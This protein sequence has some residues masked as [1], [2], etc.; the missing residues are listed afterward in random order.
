MMFQPMKAITCAGYN[1]NL[2]DMRTSEENGCLSPG[3]D[4]ISF[5]GRNAAF[6]VIVCMLSL[7]SVAVTAEDSL[8]KNTKL[9]P[10]MVRLELTPAKPLIGDT[11]TLEIRVVAEKGVELL[12]PA[13]GE[14]LDRF[15]I[16]DYVPRERIDDD[17]RTI[18][19]QRY[20]LQPPIS[21]KQSI[22]PILIE[23][24]DRRPGRRPAPDD[25]DAY[26]LLTDRLDF[27]VRSV[28]PQNADAEI[29]PPL[30][31]IK[32]R[33]PPAKPVWPWY[34][35]GGTLATLLAVA[36]IWIVSRWRRRA[37]RQSA[38]EIAHARL[39]RLLAR[40]QPAGEN[41]ESFFVELSAIIRRYLEDRFELRAPELTT[42]EFLEVA[43]DSP[44]LTGDHQRML[45][46]FLRK[47]DLVK[48]AGLQP[49]PDDVEAS[50]TSAKRFLEETRE[51]APLIEVAQNGE[52]DS[53]DVS[54]EA[55]NV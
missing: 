7:Y 41:V 24:V 47:A 52:T 46:E 8:V 43:S 32:P 36:G 29:K 2:H 30:G 20:R 45:R 22:P 53:K 25:M 48:F 12:M 51:N 31:R 40:G 19:T 18:A 37:R 34:L 6:A 33:E 5:A 28:L 26:E 42:E 44:E 14:A 16:L 55:A 15:T 21:G 10:V 50:V 13:F 1:R 4:T 3:Q 54:E 27:E 11:V 23:F 39:T 35:A 49:T 17:G 9:G 38:Y